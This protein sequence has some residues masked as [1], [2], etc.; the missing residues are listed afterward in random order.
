MEVLLNGEW[1]HVDP[2]E[3]AVDNPLLYESWG[4]NQTFI[5]SFQQNTDSEAVIVEDVTI[6]YTSNYI[7]VTERR[8]EECVNSSY[9]EKKISEYRMN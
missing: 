8:I 2:C 3:A 6:K 1:I 4:K 9:I 5:L 7:A